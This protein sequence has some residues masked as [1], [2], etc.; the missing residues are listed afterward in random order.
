MRR[1]L[2]LALGAAL[3]VLPACQSGKPTD[4]PSVK[5][6]KVRVGLPAGPDSTR[7]RPGAWCPVYVTLKAGNTPVAPNTLRLVVKTTDADDTP[8]RYTVA[9]P[10]LKPEE[11]H[12]LVT[13]TRPGS[14]A[15][16]I[17]VQVVTTD[18]RV[19]QAQPRVP[20]N[21][22]RDVLEPKEPLLVSVGSRA[23]RPDPA[24]QDEQQPEEEI[25]LKNLA[26]LDSVA[27]MPD[28]WFGYEAA[29]VLVLATG[30][31][32]FM[33]DLAS[34]RYAA[35]LD[36][37]VKWV[38]RGG[39]LVVSVGKN[40]QVVA[41][42]L[43]KTRLIDCQ[44]D[45][46]VT[47]ARA[48]KLETW[49]H[50]KD[51]EPP[52]KGLDLAVVHPG[53]GATVLLQEG[54]RKT[55]YL[56]QGSC[57]LGRVLL[58]AFDV[59]ANPFAAWAGRKGFWEQL[60]KELKVRSDVA[61]QPVP[62]GAGN[63]VAVPGGAGAVSQQ[64]EILNEIQRNLESFQ[65]VPTISFGW[66]ALF[67]LF[68]IGLVGPLDYF[69]LKKIFKRLE[70]TWVTFPATVLLVSATAYF[71]AYWLKGDDLHIKKLDV[72]DIDLRDNTQEPAQPGA[73]RRR[74]TAYGTTWFSLFSPR[75]QNYTVG[76]E[77]VSPEWVA[78]PDENDRP[79]RSWNVK[80]AT[81]DRIHPTTL[82]V[83]AGPDQGRRA[84]SAALYPQPYDC[85]EAATGLE[86]VPIPVWATRSFTASWTAPLS[87]KPPIEA[88][89]RFPRPGQG[90]ALPL[91]EITNN[92]PVALEG[93]SLFFGSDWFNLGTLEPGETRSV[94][95]VF[96]GGR[97]PRDMFFREDAL[98]PQ[99]PPPAAAA[100]PRRRRRPVDFG[101]NSE[102]EQSVSVQP[103]HSLVKQALFYAE[104]DR[105]R[106]NS[107]MRPLDQSWRFGKENAPD[108]RDEVMLVARAGPLRGNA[109]DL[110]ARGVAPTA[111]WLD[112]L[113]GT[114]P[115]RPKLDAFLTQET[116]V[117]VYIPV[118]RGS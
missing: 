108:N 20:R 77:P 81:S 28:Q 36:A 71:T 47:V 38:R 45:A 80:P 74:G 106:L 2:V 94:G 100:Q 105:S 8:F 103:F 67:T 92:L 109:E 30:N 66:V 4:L 107:G 75:I 21:V 72:V 15:S 43:Q 17:E 1:Y 111:L 25:K 5:I 37:L 39:R 58:V 14:T 95:E 42:L 98:R 34:N 117:R 115:Q 76:L 27:Q 70:L 12:P 9:V 6:E 69:L 13:Y 23:L 61:Q 26:Y 44:L 68:Y 85:T 35:Q 29:D 32:D 3:V 53:P 113:P 86:N 78:P 99:E 16:E 65:D 64:P 83:L 73:I 51:P 62:I 19:V 52:L 18:G 114:V 7:S 101:V 88:A 22:N 116:Y 110:T 118:A 46:P 55:R 41:Q 59:E 91:G 84:G 56:L 49:H 11:E 93:V 79:I 54:E 63:P 10:E 40:H 89:L 24:A 82:A 102:F 31:A 60:Q 57:G 104:T 87:G 97:Q 48:P 96:T 33:N 50:P 112:R 90:P